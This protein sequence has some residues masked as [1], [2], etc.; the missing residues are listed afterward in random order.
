MI[1]AFLNRW[2]TG[3]RASGLIGL[4]VIVLILLPIVLGA[5]SY[6]TQLLLTLFIFAVFGHGWN[7]LAGYCGL[8]SFGNQVY[9]G[10][11]GF[12]MGILAY[13]GG[14]HV[15][16]ALPIAGLV[17]AAFAYLL[18]VPV[19]HSLVGAAVLKPVA[20]AVAI[21]IGYEILVYYDPWWDI[22]G[23][24]YVRRVMILLVIFLGA[25]PLLTLEGAY[26]AVATWLIAAAV[27]TVF[28]EWKLVGA[29][30]GMRIPSTVSLEEMYYVGLVLLV[31]STWIIHALLKSKI[32]L[33]L[34]AVRDD[35]EAAATVGVDVAKVRL[36]AFVLSGGLTGLAAG[37][38]FVDAVSITPPSAFTVFWSAYFV[39]VVVAGGMGTLSGPII[40]AAIFVVID[41][42]LSGWLDQPLL[43]LGIA[44]VLVILILPRGVVGVVDA[45]RHARDG[46]AAWRD[47]FETT[48]LADLVDLVRHRRSRQTGQGVVAAWL[49]PGSPLPMLRPDADG[50]AQFREGYQDA[51]RIID[52]ARPDVIL[53]Y[54]TQWM[55][56]L[57]QLW[58][59][60]P[61]VRGVHVDEN[62]HEFGDLAYDFDIDADLALAC[63]EQSGD[64]GIRAKPVNYDHFPIDTGTIVAANALNADSK[65]P[66]ALTS[67][68]LY[69]DG[70]MTGRLAALAV[71]VA[72]DQGKR[73]AII[74]VGGLSAAQHRREIDPSEDS[75]A[76]D[77]DDYWN[78]KLL[79][80]LIAGDEAAL[81]T[82]LPDYVS[83][84]QPDMGM[85][86]L[87]W[88]LGGTAG[89]WCGAV[90]HAYGPIY[91]AGS[92]VIELALN[93]KVARRGRSRGVPDQ[94]RQRTGAATRKPAP[95]ADAPAPIAEQA[96][97]QP[98][99]TSKPARV[100]QDADRPATVAVAGAAGTNGFLYREFKTQAE[101]DAQYDVEGSVDDFG[102]YVDFFLSNSERVRK[103]LK[104]VLDIPYGPTAAEHIDFYPAR[105]PDA[106]VHLFIH[107]GYWQSLSSKEFSFVAEGLVDAGVAVAIVNYDLCPNVTMT[108]IVR[109]NRAAVKWLYEN[110]RRYNSDPDRISVSGHSAGGHLTAM[111][112]ATD[113]AGTYGLPQ[114]VVKSGCAI[115]G[116]F[117]LAPLQHSWLQPNLQLNAEEIARNSPI[118]HLPQSAGPLIVTLGGDESAEFHRQSDDFLAAWTRAGLQGTYLDL[119]G[120]NHFTVLEGYMDR[121][122]PLCDAILRQ[123]EQTRRTAG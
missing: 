109:Q 89:Q 67:N 113:W 98:T 107:G 66:L 76:G 68:N 105:A 46:R 36:V 5:N 1:G 18:A 118:H 35:A 34:T 87:D 53:V 104:P 51:A 73:V 28:N 115:S 10:I 117:D 106:P 110:A 49:V 78:R 80:A 79:D 102:V 30:G 90:V 71:Q 55:A 43:V 114:D 84:A 63:I 19:R 2:L 37:L 103:K 48:A 31:F 20:V 111:L 52:R 77:A 86:H 8:L 61:R 65:Y 4:G 93:D 101:I 116:L 25:M 121:R 97:R 32:G 15:W 29:G 33:A 64:L 39:F 85:K 72:A 26:F 6:I 50:W 21:W 3:W 112:M 123:I 13:Y 59:T 40:G 83:H 99:P 17:C 24:P 38:Y 92:A 82:M 119:P 96:E 42:M 23:D 56:V 120:A 88:L 94:P 81:R 44:S 54:S 47:L 57:D 9:V 14:V 60:R 69:H 108:E 16:I 11:G 12:T 22:F 58:Q 100:R 7:L 122:S 70:D 45:L 91:G 41:R 74:G 75:F 27:G 95:D 62:W